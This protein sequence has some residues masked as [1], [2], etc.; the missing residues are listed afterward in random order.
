LPIPTSRH[1]ARVAGASCFLNE[2]VNDPVALDQ[3]SRRFW[4][5]RPPRRIAEYFLVGDE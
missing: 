2:A 3:A 5:R 4:D 1:G